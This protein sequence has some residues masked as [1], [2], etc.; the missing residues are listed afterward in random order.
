MHPIIFDIETGP[1]PMDRIKEI[2][3]EFDPSE[4]V[5]P[6]EFDQAK[7]K[8]GNLKDQ[9][10]IIAKINAAREAHEAAVDGYQYKLENAEQDYWNDLYKNGALSSLTG[11][12]LA[13]GYKSIPPEKEEFRIMTDYQSRAMTEQ[14]ILEK[15]WVIFQS[16][17]KNSRQMIG[18]NIFEFDIPFLTQRSYVLG[19]PVPKSLFNGRYL[20]SLF[21]D[22]YKVW[23]AGQWKP[24]GSLDA[25]ARAC[26]IGSKKGKSGAHFFE[27]FETNLDEAIE[28]LKND[29]DISWGIAERL[30]LV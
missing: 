30:G 4:I 22:T 24:K 12:V 16:S 26:G 13:I 18:H 5:H 7:V 8:V 25:I 23:G 2:M 20:N 6:G 19:V 11:Q 15:F 10:K 3:P 17:A 21:V 27:L 9:A 14:Q 1:L 29:L 28:Y